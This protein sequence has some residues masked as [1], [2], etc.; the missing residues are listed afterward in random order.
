MNFEQDLL[1]SYAHLDD[2]ALVEG[3]AGWVSR[4][5]RLLEIRVGQL[6]G[7]KPRIWR[8]PKLQ[9]NDFF[10]DTILERLPK[11]GALVSVL[12]PRYVQSEWCTRELKEFCRASETS[13]G[14]R[15]ADKARIF[16]VVKTPVP[17]E[18]HPQEVQPFLGYEF[19]VVDPQ[20]GRP[21]ELA[22]AYGPDAERAFLAKLDDLAYDITKLLELLRH[23]GHGTAPEVRRGTVYLAETSFDLRDEREAVKRDL[24]RNGYEVLPDQ[25]LPL[26]SGDFAAAVGAQLAR[27]TLSIHLIG[28]NY[29]IVPEGETHSI[30]VLQHEIAAERSAA[31]GLSRLIWLP[32][33]LVVEDERQRELLGYLH[34]APSVHA[35]AE[36]LEVP[37]E[38]LKTLIYRQ[39]APPESAK[40]A[41]PSAS[42]K[43]LTHLYLVCDQPDI[44]AVRPL[45]DFLFDQGFEVA[46][47]L[48]DEDEAQARL[49]HEESLCSS[50]AVLFFYGEAGE[51]WLRRKLRE[52]Q[53]S[54]GLGRE[55]PLLARGIYVG[56][57]STPQKERFRTLEA[58][59]L[60]EPADGFSPDALAP[61]LAEIA[62]VRG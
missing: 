45:E 59:V 7:E 48:F 61:F 2:Q 58:T 43:E 31:D 30:V 39:L 60:R 17:A 41:T 40:K 54:A 29:G 1:I 4:L 24:V 55:K 52:L 11:V 35:G 19:Y 9:G 33:G 18:R 22:Q 26:V 47:P 36:L 28:K 62:Q 50:D 12:S 16:K 53:K 20:S 44:E 13:G 46:L 49:D 27:C 3:E 15:I 5:H 23:N 57:P 6:L 14:I 51:P 38:D 25:P 21:R 37:L 42:K 56:N 10:A 8:D 34:T 32:P